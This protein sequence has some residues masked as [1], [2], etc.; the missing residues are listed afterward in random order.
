MFDQVD[1]R[2]IN[3]KWLRSQIS[4]PSPTTRAAQDR[5]RV[6]ADLDECSQPLL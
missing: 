6:S 2:S 3:V 5:F 4:K 1:A